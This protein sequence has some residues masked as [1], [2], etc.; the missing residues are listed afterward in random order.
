VEYWTGD[1]LSDTIRQRDMKGFRL[2]LA[3]ILISYLSVRRGRPLFPSNDDGPG[4]PNDVVE[5]EDPK[6]RNTTPIKG[7]RDRDG[8]SIVDQH[9]T[10]DIILMQQNSTRSH[11]DR[12]KDGFLDSISNRNL[13]LDKK[14]M[15]GILCDYITSIDDAVT[16]DKS[17]V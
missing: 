12:S 4:S 3:A 10:T 11:R 8:N 9:G 6:Q 15:I 17:W 13:N 1:V 2:K 5:I 7:K 16:L 14:E